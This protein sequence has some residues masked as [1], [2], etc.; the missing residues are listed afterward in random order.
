MGKSKSKETKV[1]YVALIIMGIAL[2]GGGGYYAYDRLAAQSADDL[3][4]TADYIAFNPSIYSLSA[5]QN[6]LE[7]FTGTEYYFEKGTF[8]DIELANKLYA[9]YTVGQSTT[10]LDKTDHFVYES[11][12]L[13]VFKV[14]HAD[15]WD[16]WFRNWN[17]GV[18]EAQLINK[19]ASAN[20]VIWEYYGNSATFNQ[21][22]YTHYAGLICA[23]TLD[24]DFVCGYPGYCYDFETNAYNRTGVMITFNT[25]YSNFITWSN[26]DF[27]I[28]SGSSYYLLYDTPL[29]SNDPIEV[30]FK[31]AS[32]VG[33]TFIPISATAVMGSAQSSFTSISSA[34]V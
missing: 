26:A 21:S 32:T 19:S 6:A 12:E 9:S 20:V 13:Q 30:E 22:E 33:T 7:A 10:L 8:S 17:L 4:I 11:D 34:Y 23:E 28:P 3:S 5:T 24:E 27:V 14:S 2:L 1:L 25:T 31:L 29:L 18:N 15:C 16:V